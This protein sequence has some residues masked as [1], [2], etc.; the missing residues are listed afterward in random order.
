MTTMTPANELE[1]VPIAALATRPDPASWNAALRTL[2]THARGDQWIV[3]TPQDV[4]AALTA[5]SLHVMPPP[6]GGGPAADLVARMARFCDG[7][8]HQRR[9][10]LTMTLLPP[11]AEVAGRA[12]ACAAHY[13]RVR[14]A[15]DLLDV[16]PLARTVPALA[17][18][19]AMGLSSPE[20]VSAAEATGRLCDAPRCPSP[21]TPR[22]ATTTTPA[23]SPIW[24]P[25]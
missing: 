16:M 3:S 10:A 14:A 2:G 12:Y 5:P 6:V 24:P 23:R 9:R 11:A 7:E 21:W 25:S 19:L 17:L 13:L 1:G 4:A 15:A 20:A 18:G 8:A 22:A